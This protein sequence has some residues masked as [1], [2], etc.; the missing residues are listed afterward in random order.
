M[1]KDCVNYK[2]DD[3]RAFSYIWQM[4]RIMEKLSSHLGHESYNSYDR[5]VEDLYFMSISIEERMMTPVKYGL[6][7]SIM[8]FYR[9][10]G[11]TIHPYRR[12]H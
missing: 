12:F 2:K 4:Q 6:E 5:I 11:A 1:S 10:K 7:P 8:Q 9:S 3:P